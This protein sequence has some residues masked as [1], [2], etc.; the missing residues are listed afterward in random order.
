[1][2]GNIKARH[3]LCVLRKK[4][5]CLELIPNARLFMRHRLLQV[6][7]PVKINQDHQIP[8]TLQLITHLKWWLSMENISEGRFLGQTQTTVTITTDASRLGCGRVLSKNCSGSLDK[9]KEVTAHKEIETVFLTLK[10]F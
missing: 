1:M 9:S 5:S 6:W 10:Y 4:A 7:I 2:E 8:C 3:Y